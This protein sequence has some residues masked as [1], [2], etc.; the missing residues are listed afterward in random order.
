MLKNDEKQIKI[1]ETGSKW[2]RADFHLHTRADKEF[3]YTKKLH[4]FASYNKTII[5]SNNFQGKVCFTYN[6]ITNFNCYK[7]QK[8]L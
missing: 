7:I 5:S 4:V 2:L 1:F 6:F 3:I 8:K